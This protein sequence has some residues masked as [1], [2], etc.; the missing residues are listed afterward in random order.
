MESPPHG[1]SLVAHAQISAALAEGTRPQNEVLASFQ[2]NEKQWLESTTYWLPKLA[3][4][5]QANGAQARLAIE[6]SDAFSAAQDSFAPVKPMTAEEWAVLV[7]EVQRDENPSPP[8]ARRQLSLADYFRLAR[9]FARL[10]SSDPTEQKRYLDRY[11]SLQP[12][13]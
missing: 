13:D 7:V 9:H 8:L 5:A 11:L 12:S 6:Y 4:D 2:L 1:I 10:L 3:E